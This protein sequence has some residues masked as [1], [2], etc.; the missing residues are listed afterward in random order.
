MRFKTLLLMGA[1][2]T[3]TVAVATSAFADQ[4]TEQTEKNERVVKLSDIPAPARKGLER[5]AKGAPITRVEQFQ[6]NGRTVYEGLIKQGKQ[7]H[8]IVVDAS[9]KL[10]ERH[11]EQNEKQ[12]A[13][14]QNHSQN[15]NEK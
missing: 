13:Q 12:P 15:M 5:E 4:K 8:G 11:S 7:E 6:Q 10:V 2:A 1:L 9:G 14:N 3:P